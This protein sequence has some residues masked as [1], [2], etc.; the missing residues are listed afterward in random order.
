[1]RGVSTSDPRM[2]GLLAFNQNRKQDS[3]EKH[4]Q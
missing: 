4:N 1:M 2:A 3:R